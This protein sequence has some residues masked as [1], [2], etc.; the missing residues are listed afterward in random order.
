HS[1][2]C[3]IIDVIVNID[4]NGLQQSLGQLLPAE[5]GIRVSTAAGNLVLGGHASSSPAAQQAMQIAQAFAGAQPTQQSQ[6]AS[7]SVGNGATSVSQ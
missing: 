5:R 1:G 7:G 3:Q 2:S 6:A 4:P